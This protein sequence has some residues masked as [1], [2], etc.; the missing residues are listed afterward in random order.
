MSFGQNIQ[1][2]RK[3]HKGMTQEELA[4]KMGFSTCIT[5]ANQCIPY[6]WICCSLYFTF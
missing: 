2:L 6:A 1:F 3:M 5:G 4:E